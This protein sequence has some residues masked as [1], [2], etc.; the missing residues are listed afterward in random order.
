MEKVLAA[1]IGTGGLSWLGLL[2]SRKVDKT[3]CDATR[4]GMCEKL[5]LIKEDLTYIRKR[6]DG[7]IDGAS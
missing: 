5:D 1:I 6:I 3:A 7:H 4:Q 2:Q